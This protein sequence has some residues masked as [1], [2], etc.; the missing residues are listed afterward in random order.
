MKHSFKNS[1]MVILTLMSLI[2]NAV[3]VTPA[4]ADGSWEAVGPAGFSEGQAKY[5]SLALYNG[6]P[7]VAYQDGANGNA[8]VK[9][10]NEGTGWE[11]V[12]EAGF[13]A[14]QAD[15]ISLVIHN[16]TPYVAYQ[17][18]GTGINGEAT[19]MKFNGTD[20]VVVGTAGFSAG[21]AQYT[22]L[23][24]D[25]DGTPYVG[26]RD[27]A[28][29]DDAT[30]MKFNGTDW[31][32]VGTAGFS[33]GD[34]SYLS[35]A[36]DNGIP[37]VA[38]KDSY[39]GGQAMV[40][41]FNEGTGWEA[42]GPAGVS[43]TSADY[44]SLAL[45]NGIPYVA[46]RDW[47]NERKATVKK[48]NGTDWVVVGTAGFSEGQADYTSLVVDNGTPYVA[49]MDVD[50]S[51]KA[52]VMQFNGTGWGVVG[53][54]GFSAGQAQY[55]S[56]ALDHTLGNITAF[57]AYMD[58]PNGNQ[59]TVMKNTGPAPFRTVTFNANGGTGSLTPQ[60][61]NSP[62]ALTLNTSITR[63]DYFFTGW[64]TAANGSGTPYS[65]GDQ[66]NFLADITLYAQWSVIANA[67]DFD[68]ADDYVTGSDTGF[69]TGNSPRT[70][71]AWVKA[72]AQGSFGPIM[73]WGSFA[74]NQ[75]SALGVSATG[76]AYWWGNSNDLDSEIPINNG[77]WHHIAG[78]YDGTTLRL[79]VDGNLANSVV[80]TL[81]TVSD[82]T[83]QIGLVE[84]AG[85]Y[86]QGQVDEVRVWNVA[87]SAEDIQSNMHSEVSSPQAGLV[88]YYKFN[89]GVAGGNNANPP[90][91]TAIDSGGSLLNGTLNNFALT[92]ST[93]NW[94]TEPHTVTFAANG[95]S[96]SMLPQVANTASALTL[97]TFTRAGY[98]FTGWN[99]MANGSGTAY[100]NG[101]QYNFLADITLYARWAPL[102]YHTVI[103]KA[104]GGSG[105]MPNQVA[106]VPTALTA[107]AFTRTSHTF[108]GWN[109]AA[110]GSGTTYLNGAE[111]DFSADIT[112]YAQWISN[113]LDFDGT[114][115]YVSG[116]DVGF[117]TGNSPRTIEAW[118][119]VTGNSWKPILEYGTYTDNQFSALVVRPEGTVM[120]WGHG[121]DVSGTTPVND[122][123]WHH[124]AGSYDGTTVSIYVDGSWDG[125]GIEDFDTLSNGI[126]HIGYAAGENYYN[127]GQ[128]DEVRVWDVARTEGEI[129]D[130]MNSELSLQA[131][132]VAYYKFNQG[133]AGG[134]NIGVTTAVDSSGSELDGTL[135]NFA[136]T[137]ST[138]NWVAGN[139][140]NRDFTAPNAPQVIEPVNTS[141]TTPTISGTAEA[142]SFVNVWYWDGSDYEPLCEDVPVD[143]FGNWSCESSVTLPE[144]EIALA[145]VAVDEAGNESDP[146]FHFF[147]VVVAP[148]AA[149]TLDA[150][151][152]Y[153]GL[154]NP[155]YT[156]DAV[157]GATWYYLWVDGPAGN[158][159]MKW[160]AA[161]EADCDATTCS[162]ANVTP[163]LSAG[164]Y[165]WWIR[166]WNDAGYGSWSA[167]MTFNPLP[168]P[169]SLVSPNGYIGLNNP[170]YTWNAVPGATQYYLWVEG[171]AGNVHK[172]WYT[173][174]AANCNANTCS[175]SNVTTGLTAGTYTWWI[176]T[177]NPIG[178]GPWS[179][180]V[181]FNPLPGPATLV[182]PN[183]NSGTSNPTY[184][185]S[186]VPNVT[187]YYLWVEG[188]AGNVHKKWY[189]SAETNCDGTTCSLSD[190]T[191][192]LTAGTYT[193][194]IQTWNPIG[195]GP[196]S[197]AMTFNPL[198]GQAILTS[199]TGTLDQAAIYTWEVVPGATWYYLWVNG[200]AGNIHQ[201]WYTAVEANCNATTCSLSNVTTEL[202]A[203]TYTWWIQTWNAI[204]YGP[205]SDAMTFSPAVPGVATLV[206]PTGSA[207]TN[208]PTYTWNEVNDSTWYYLWVDGP[209]GNVHKKW[210]TS[211]E[212]NCDGT[213]CS[214]T[215]STTLSSGAHKWWI[216]TWNEAGYGPW[217][218]AVIFQT[219]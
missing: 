79:Y 102:Q 99:T 59:A 108:T 180:E 115:D 107:N 5:T 14:G 124:I 106:N 134:N 179:A 210:Y 145:V 74:D 172:Q 144:G 194:W 166:T 196:W 66:Y 17:D 63:T 126:F 128:V 183:G 40:K 135:N 117:P 187:W 60:T 89:Q 76:T 10:F 177:W 52:T 138:S 147:T 68:G 18:W 30:V 139:V 23:A 184:T 136:L 56:L 103:F 188:P 143:E 91:I 199:P 186:Q 198:P 69:P 33:D 211:A 142:G 8:T 209:A 195:Y 131:G 65:D 90:V 42:V 170:T 214:I 207:G 208:N 218:E 149:A 98:V 185:W 44:T 181:T 31:V 86:Y 168:G 27:G 104:N 204:G 77:Q 146:T 95:G 202:T 169:A 49:Y 38:Y 215:P 34:A 82:G 50:N 81:N 151:N 7:Y 159:H 152:G 19:V 162:L 6:T 92:G 64:N 154:N 158:V 127:H 83:F 35:L 105:S 178:Y 167:E 182:S 122:G 37:Y 189:T 85:S 112:L 219:P 193:W 55:T 141:D 94:V 26:Y 156:W 36:L 21:Q 153:I 114:N 133:V 75:N 24:L 43:T 160:Y 163:G 72:P 16:G 191:T 137:G 58:F 3:G 201:Q 71:E 132:L 197:T 11:A 13:S 125:E 150:P 217:S 129:Y 41:K 15:Y 4:Y 93:S 216:R 96:G 100:A 70:I 97:N 206:S 73:E 118:V 155:T 28:S 175:L 12:G 54:A 2:I 57:V 192:G 171:P 148:P 101:A 1:L 9:K 22:S 200:P 110:D 164:T 130:N 203:G 51:E 157:P 116:S 165:T 62:T 78:T 46:Y 47:G 176:Q 67:L 20:W 174:A 80:T 39:Y 140:S 119:R 113:A 213:T 111:Y 29:S 88:A 173:S 48:F 45:D 53:T 61:A 120:W 212:T 161:V 109:T 84:G 123:Q 121:H 205:W 25:N 87:R 32:V 190:V